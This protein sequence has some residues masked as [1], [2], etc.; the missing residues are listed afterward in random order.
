MEKMDSTAQLRTTPPIDY[1]T[2]VAGKNANCVS[3]SDFR[4]LLQHCALGA[5]RPIDD[6]TCL[7]G[8]I[9]NSNLIVSAW[10]TRKMD[11]RLI[12]IARAITDFHYACYLSDL[13]VDSTYQKQG[14]GKT[15]I[16]RLTQAVEPTCKIILIAAPAANDYY[17]PLGFERNERCWVLNRD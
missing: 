8:M 12:A 9:R 4:S 17:A 1:H 10:D 13:A 5:R 2:Y 11:R 7:D 3:T 15:L 14:V 6:I 16:K